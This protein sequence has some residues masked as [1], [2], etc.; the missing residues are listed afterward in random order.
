M[1]TV[2][3]L[4]GLFHRV[5]LGQPCH[6]AENL[7]LAQYHLRRH[8][9]EDCGSDP[10]AI[11]MLGHR[12]SPAVQEKLGPFLGSHADELHHLVPGGSGDQGA[13]S[14]SLVQ[15]VADSERCGAVQ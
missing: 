10:V 6:R 8:A 7:F 5:H 9:L 12:N 2:H 11:R 13:H 4:D 1:D 15:P 14:D 3:E